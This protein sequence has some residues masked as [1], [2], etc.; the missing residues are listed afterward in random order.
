MNKTSEI[1]KLMGKSSKLWI[2]VA[3]M[4]ILTVLNPGIF[5]TLNNMK[6]ILLAISIY[7]IMLCGAIFPI[8]MGGI[9]LSVGAVAASAGAF[10]VTWIVNHGETDLSVVVG[11]LGGLAIGALAGIFHSIIIT[12]FAVPAFL[13]TLATQN[14][15]YGIAQLFTNNN[16]IPCMDPPSF[17]FLG[18]G[19]LLGIPFSIYIM[20]AMAVISHILLTKTV[21]GRYVYAVGGNYEAC[22]LSGVNSNLISLL[23]YMASGLTSALA[24]IVLASMNRQAI[25]KAA[26]GYDN[27]VITA[28]VVGGASLMGGEGTIVGAIWGAFLVGAI[29]NGLRLMGL[30]SEYHGIVKCVVIVA[31]VAIDANARFRKSGLQKGGLFRKTRKS[32]N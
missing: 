15:I 21:F 28:V 25:A 22:R 26:Q 14:I 16:V 24:G 7:G 20:I 32:A 4:L 31:A 3:V 11:V 18:G 12:R 27:Y 13:V 30:A 5:L 1:R 10:T 19:V 8:L 23:S 17:A 6:S 2:L 9:D 29:S